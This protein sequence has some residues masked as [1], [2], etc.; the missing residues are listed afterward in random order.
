MSFVLNRTCLFLNSFYRWR[1]PQC[2]SSTIFGTESLSS[3]FPLLQKHQPN[4]AAVPSKSCT[5]SLS[6]WLDESPSS[7]PTSQM[8]IPVQ[9]SFKKRRCTSP[10]RAPETATAATTTEICLD[11]EDEDEDLMAIIEMD[12]EA[13]RKNAVCSSI[14]DAMAR[15]VDVGAAIDARVRKPQGRVRRIR[16]KPRAML[17][18]SRVLLDTGMEQNCVP[19]IKL[20]DF[21]SSLNLSDDTLIAAGLLCASDIPSFR[22]SKRVVALCCQQPVFCKSLCMKHYNKYQYLRTAVVRQNFTK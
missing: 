2:M 17:M 7:L 18:V 16:R 5:F 22:N 15:M 9:Q 11:E 8:T 1:K 6:R 19:A 21:L 10:E 13:Q 3:S 14:V 4:N 12:L 20:A